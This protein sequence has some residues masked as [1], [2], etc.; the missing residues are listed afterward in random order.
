MREKIKE[1]I[2]EHWPIGLLVLVS[3]IVYHRW[4]SFDIFLNVDA[5]FYFSEA[6]RDFLRY[7]TWNSQSYFGNN[8]VTLWMFGLT[9]FSGLFGWFGL[10]SNIS[11]KF[12]ILWPFVF[13]TP[14]FS[15]FFAKEV[16]K[17]KLGAFVGACVYSFNTYYIILNTQGH[18]GVSLSGT[19]APLAMLFFWRYFERG[20]VKNLIASALTT[21]LIGAYD[22]RTVYILFFI[23]L[24]L[25]FWFLFAENGMERKKI[26][27]KR[28][29]R[30]LVLFFSLLLLFNI[31]W[32]WPAITSESFLSNE[33]VARDIMAR[34]YSL[35]LRD[36]LT[37]FHPFWN[38]SEPGWFKN[39]PV[40]LYFW[41]I[42]IMVVISAFWARKNKNILFWFFIAL[43]AIF[44]SKQD[45]EPLIGIYPWF[46]G[47]FPGFNAFREATK[48]YFA[49]ALA[50]SI[51]IGYFA[52]RIYELKSV[53][54]TVMKPVCSVGRESNLIRSSRR[55]R[56]LGTIKWVVISLIAGIFLW[57]IKPI[58]T[59]EI[60]KIFTPKHIS[61]DE[62][63]IREFILKQEDIFRSLYVS[64]LKFVSFS[65]AHPVVGMNR[66]YSKYFDILLNAGN[67]QGDELDG[68]EK[69][70]IALSHN[71]ATNL[72]ASG[73]IAYL[74]VKK[75]DFFKISELVKNPAWKEIALGLQ[76]MKIFENKVVKPRIYLSE[77]KETIYQKNYFQSIDFSSVNSA[78]WDIAIPELKN[79]MWLNFSESY[80]P[81][82]RLVCGDFYWYDA[83]FNHKMF[84]VK[85]HYKTDAGLS[86]FWLDPSEAQSV[87]GEGDG[88]SMKLSL[89]YLPQ[90]YFYLGGIITFLTVLGSILTLVFWREKRDNNI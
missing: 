67:F 56:L 53:I 84:S 64:E 70:R 28:N 9:F 78:R 5:H 11:D 18:Y 25:P 21:L 38:G 4:L 37:L 45:A 51:L 20:K 80:H 82:W 86:T 52:G 55:L 83:F 49:I 85:N 75:E 22:F 69:D 57:N 14:I 39:Q 46:H 47:H 26:F 17:N 90:A 60:Y 72:I 7:S 73:N 31:F 88:E 66:M 34:N 54:P 89:F 63:T 48:F 61:S 8:N 33:T 79:K 27:F 29:F 15:Y 76:D 87:C 10:D 42:P 36:T 62:K 2:A 68:T 43:I 30:P 77:E 59:G 74:T 1:F 65:N 81:K 24:F 41:L 44:V 35:D 40:S 13:L 16:L 32:V 58:L 50:Y 3:A 23:L 6:S 71:A 19:F 12:V